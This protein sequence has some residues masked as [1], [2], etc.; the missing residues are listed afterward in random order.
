MRSEPTAAR[1]IYVN[2]IIK[3]EGQGRISFRGEVR[4]DDLRGNRISATATPFTYQ[5]WKG[6]PQGELF[7]QGFEYG[8]SE[9]SKAVPVVTVGCGAD[10]PQLLSAKGTP[11]EFRWTTVAG[12]TTY[13]VWLRRSGG[14]PR[15]IATTIGAPAAVPMD[16]G[17]Y[18]WFVEANMSGC[19]SVMSEAAPVSVKPPRRRSV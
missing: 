15:V 9:M 16:A 17:D 8:T 19:P 4:G 13:N 10:L 18:E 14:A 5:G 1:T 11:I 7:G 2:Y 3:D 6:P 12:A